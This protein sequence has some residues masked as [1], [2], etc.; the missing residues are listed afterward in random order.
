MLKTKQRS[1]M[2][3][4]EL[5]KDLEII[6]PIE[7]KTILG[8]D[9]YPVSVTGYINRSS[10]YP[11]DA[12]NPD[13]LPVLDQDPWDNWGEPGSG[14]DNNLFDDL[15]ENLNDQ[16]R[17]T[18]SDHICQQFS[19]SGACAPIAFS[20][21]ANHF[22][23]NG[24]TSSDFAEMRGYNYDLMYGGFGGFNP[25]DISSIVSTV[26]KSSC[27]SGSTA[28]IESA[29]NKGEPI[30]AQ[31]TENNI[32]YHLVVI[33]GFDSIKGNVT[34]MDPNINKPVTKNVNDI[35]F[36]SMLYS[37]QGVQNTKYVNQYRNDSN[38]KSFCDICKK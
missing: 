20:Y 32:P 35:K 18:F 36:D 9:L 7:S 2:Q 27:I 15:G 26:F 11:R 6:N 19:T 5:H 21:V 12:F 29:L 33:T 3:F 4:S 30:L 8:G 22:G 25:N 38:D 24:L 23:A 10:L 13:W 1:K 17:D 14:D 31:I 28:S 34:Y 16:K 37:I